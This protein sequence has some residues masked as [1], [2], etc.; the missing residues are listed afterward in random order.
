[1]YY[2]KLCKVCQEKLPATSE[3][4]H[5]QKKGKFGLRTVCKNVLLIQPTEKQEEN[6]IVNIIKKTELKLSA[7]N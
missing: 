6:I 5:K 4:F 7:I 2:T 3:Y 1:M